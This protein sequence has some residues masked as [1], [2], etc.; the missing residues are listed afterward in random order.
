MNLFHTF[1]TLCLI[2]VR[3]DCQFRKQI[4]YET[5]IAS[6][7]GVCV[8]VCVCLCVCVCVH[9]CLCV[10]VYVCVCVFVC[11]CRNLEVTVQNRSFRCLMNSKTRALC[12]ASLTIIPHS[13]PS[14][15][16]IPLPRRLASDDQSPRAVSLSGILQFLCFVF[17]AGCN[18]YSFS[19]LFLATSQTWW[20]TLSLQSTKWNC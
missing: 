14:K 11:V 7:I 10:F 5:D 6:A 19:H 3:P 9:V 17:F 12:L 18:L 8:Y 13:H 1:Y 4:S 16:H 2:P 20:Y 15:Q